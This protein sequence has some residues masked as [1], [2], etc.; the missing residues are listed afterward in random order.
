MNRIF[1]LETEWD[2]SVQNL[3]KKSAAES[4]LKFL[5]NTIEVPHIFR[6]VAT[7][8]DFEFYI[9]RLNHNTYS[10]YDMIYL[11]FH[12]E[13]KEIMFANG[14]NINICT[15]GSKHPNIFLNRNVHF[16]SCSSLRMKENE[17][18]EFKQ[19]TNAR[20]ITGYT[21]DVD[22]MKSFVFELWLLNAIAS[23]P[24]YSAKGI[25]K[26]AMDEMPYCVKRFGF[27]AY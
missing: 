26:R 8:Q 24:N 1:C 4:L 14:V 13:K 5:E 25:M 6:Q 21:R 22:F 9:N 10:A 12:G 2:K 3:K 19:N 7:S 11:C 27:V 17:I 15:F 16:G 23:Y 20:M 18:R